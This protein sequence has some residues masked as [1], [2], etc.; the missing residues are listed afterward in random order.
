MVDIIRVDGLGK[1]YLDGN[2]E[3]LEILRNLALGFRREQTVSIV[4]SS[5]SGKSTLLNLLGGLDHPTTGTV[6]YEDEDIY[7]YDADRLSDWRNRRIGFIFQSHHLLPDFNAFENV[8]IPALIAGYGKT[9]I[10]RRV[11]TLLTQVGLQDRKTHKPSQLS[12][13]EQQR[14]AIAR[15]LINQPAII[16]ADE[17]TGNLDNQT[18]ERVA[19][20]LREICRQQRATLIMV[21]HN[22]QL[23]AGMDVRLRLFN[24]TLSET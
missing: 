16:L 2:G 6:Y 11:E 8:M 17:P 13:G 7:G 23:A 12:G 1:H 3:R 24:G 21:T 22:L 20:L 19:R 10:E 5:G 18:G 15:A 14:V 9:D 4:G